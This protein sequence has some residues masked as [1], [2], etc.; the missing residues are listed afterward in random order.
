MEEVQ[1]DIIEVEEEPE[2]EIVEPPKRQ[3]KPKE[4]AKKSTAKK[5]KKEVVVE[6]IEPEPEMPEIIEDIDEY[7]EEE[8]V[9]EP[10]VVEE[11]HIVEDKKKPSARKS[12]KKPST[13]KHII[14]IEE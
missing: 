7:M 12:A 4:S 6:E 3:R 13:K 9:F 11:I 1:E 2:E 14:Q 5:F 8:H 10:E